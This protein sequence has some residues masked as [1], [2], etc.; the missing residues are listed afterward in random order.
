MWDQVHVVKVSREELHFISQ[1][2]DEQAAID[3]LWHD[4]PRLLVITDGPMGCR[5]VTQSTSGHVDGF[6]VDAVDTTGAGDGFVRG[7]W[8]QSSKMSEHWTT[9]TN[10]NLPYP[11]CDGIETRPNRYSVLEV[12]RRWY[13]DKPCEVH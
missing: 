8:P 1:E 5:Y 9:F 4:D 11:T 3:A 10:S 12:W 7:Y 6:A 2:S 13:G